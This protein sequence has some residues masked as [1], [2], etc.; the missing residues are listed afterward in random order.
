[1]REEQ[2]SLKADLMRLSDNKEGQQA[3]TKTPL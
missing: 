2:R 3:E 1:V